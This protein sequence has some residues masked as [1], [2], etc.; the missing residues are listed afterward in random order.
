MEYPNEYSQEL[1]FYPFPVK[2]DTLVGS[3]TTL[4]NLFNKLCVLNKIEDL[5]INVFNMI[6]G[7]MKQKFQQK[8]YHVNAN[9]N[10]MEKIKSKVV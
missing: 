2:L 10:L 5:N 7:K 6:A 8:I 9:T 1:H 3:C 4:N